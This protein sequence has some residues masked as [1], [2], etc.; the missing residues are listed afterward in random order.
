MMSGEGEESWRRREKGN[1]MLGVVM[2]PAKTIAV[3]IYAG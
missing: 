2:K 3:S 1:L